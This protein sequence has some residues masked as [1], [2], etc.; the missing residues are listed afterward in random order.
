MAWGWGG[1]RLQRVTLQK[2]VP[3]AVLKEVPERSY[4]WLEPLDTCCEKRA[5]RM[6]TP[7]STPGDVKRG[8][9]RLLR[10][11]RVPGSGLRALQE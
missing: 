8:G 7:T 3:K 4:P 2:L 1:G 9:S 5:P 11:Y 10:L 6:A